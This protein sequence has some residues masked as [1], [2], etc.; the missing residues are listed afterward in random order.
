MK[1]KYVRICPVCNST[2]VVPDMS[3]ESYARGLL[4]QWKCNACGH[5]GLFFPEY[6][7][8]DLKKIKEKS[9]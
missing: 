5:S 1:E 4:N 8:E 6:T 7:P 3:A 2:D 9:K